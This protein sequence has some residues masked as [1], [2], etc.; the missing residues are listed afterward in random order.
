[1]GSTRATAWLDWRR[2][3]NYFG[4][5]A[6]PPPGTDFR[7]RVV[8]AERPLTAAESDTSLGSLLDLLQQ[9]GVSPSYLL[10]SIRNFDVDVVAD[11]LRY[12]K[13]ALVGRDADPQTVQF[14]I[15]LLGSIPPEKWAMWTKLVQQVLNQVEFSDEVRQFIEADGVEDFLYQLI[16]RTMTIQKQA[17][18]EP[19]THKEALAHA[20]LEFM[21]NATSVV[22]GDPNVAVLFD[23][24]N[25]FGSLQAYYAKNAIPGATVQKVSE[26]GFDADYLVFGRQEVHSVGKREGVGPQP[27]SDRLEDLVNRVIG[28]TDRPPAVPVDVDR[29]KFRNEIAPDLELVRK[30]RDVRAG[31][32]VIDRL[33]A[34]LRQRKKA[35]ARARWVVGAAAV[36][37]A[38]GQ[39]EQLR[40]SLQAPDTETAGPPNRVMAIRSA[41][42]IPELL[43]DDTRLGSWLFKPDGLIH[44]E[45]SRLLLDPA[46]PLIEFWLDTFPEF[47]GVAPLYPG[48]NAK[49]ER[50]V[51]IES[52]D[53]DDRLL[54]L[55]G[56]EGT[57]QFVLEALAIDAYLANAEKL[58]VFAAPWGRS[59]DFANYVKGLRSPS[60]TYFESYAFEGVDPTDAAL[61]VSQAGNHHYSEVF[62]Y[63]T[64]ISGTI[65]FGFH[66]I[67]A[68]GITKEETGDRGVY[69]VSLKSFLAE[70]RLLDRLP[71]KEPP[72]IRGA[73]R[74]TDR[75]QPHEI[76][77]LRRRELRAQ[78][79]AAARLGR[80]LSQPEILLAHQD[81]DPA[82][83]TD[84]LRVYAEVFPDYPTPDT[85]EFRALLHRPD[86]ELITVRSR[87]RLAAFGLSSTQTALPGSLFLDVLGVAMPFQRRGVGS[88]LLDLWAEQAS[89]RGN[90][91][92]YGFTRYGPA[93]VP[94]IR[95]YT[96]NHFQVLGP[97]GNIGQL[98][99]RPVSLMG[100]E[101]QKCVEAITA[102]LQNELRAQLAKPRISVH[103]STSPELLAIFRDIQRSFPELGRQSDEGFA[104][105]MRLPDALTILIWDGPQPVAFGLSY[106]DPTLPARLVVA[107]AMAVH[108]D[109]QTRSVGPLFMKAML[110]I[111]SLTRYTSALKSSEKE[112]GQELLPLRIDDVWSWVWPQHG[113]DA[114]AAVS[115][116]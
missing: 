5:L 35:L 47:L 97:Y 25:Q 83:I 95:F 88:V 41:K 12:L 8:V 114:A 36:D 15:N 13:I 7:P 116:N 38:I 93:S 80:S 55:R 4:P 27:W 104:F 2:L 109:C 34:V 40:S 61:A 66:V 63:N 98:I 82:V 26:R 39:A 22:G 60:I 69:E 90:D 14:H 16:L 105:K 101:N 59:A 72:V 111:L 52:L 30:N 21:E 58:I 91:G 19:R 43:F 9:A 31:E 53:Y 77:E 65:D 67:S 112:K 3:L 54:G 102:R 45:I 42:L 107:D 74:T 20:A 11:L 32:R 100:P 106:H 85:R 33:L 103:T 94:L 48:L 79:S 64:P 96:R 6:P 56:P 76:R 81:A 10:Q 57:S 84:V 50:T 46:T 37:D 23:A 92:M 87:G 110:A 99:F 17:E 44:G 51:L 113:S 75:P 24:V 62:G 89:I 49:K 78:E 115:S 68:A 29:F 86:A 108:P 28:S 1:M 73:D 18:L 70:S 71:R